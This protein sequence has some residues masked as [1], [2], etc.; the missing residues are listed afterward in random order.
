M[1]LVAR[2]LLFELQAS[3]DLK[4]MPVEWKNQSNE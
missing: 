1:L 2:L 3:S 4:L